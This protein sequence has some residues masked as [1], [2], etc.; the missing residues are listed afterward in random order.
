MCFIFRC[1]Y[2]LNSQKVEF[3]VVIFALTNWHNVAY[4]IDDLSIMIRNL[5]I[6]LDFSESYSKSRD[7]INPVFSF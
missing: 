2:F 7:I 5:F 3:K 1:D 4:R 6:N